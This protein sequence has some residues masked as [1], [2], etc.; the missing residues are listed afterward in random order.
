MTCITAWQRKLIKRDQIG[1]Y[2]EGGGGGASLHDGGGEG[3]H[4][5]E[6][7]DK[8]QGG[9]D[10]GIEGLAKHLVGHPRAPKADAPDVCIRILQ[11]CPRCS[12]TGSN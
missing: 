3:G 4:R 6:A 8:A 9:A 2:R 11:C 7:M 5:I 1:A 12:C 10:Q